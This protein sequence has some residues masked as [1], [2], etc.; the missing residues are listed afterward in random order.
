MKLYTGERRIKIIEKLLYIHV[1]GDLKMI[2]MIGKCSIF[3]LLFVKK[4]QSTKLK[5]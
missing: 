3:F 2:I 4:L 5:S 1:H